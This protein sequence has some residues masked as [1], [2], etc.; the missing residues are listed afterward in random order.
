MTLRDLRSY[1]AYLDERGELATVEQQVEPRFEISA[2]IRR[3]SDA[4]GPA[5]LFNQV[6]NSQMRVVGGLFCSTGKAFHFRPYT[7]ALVQ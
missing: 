2:F 6:A 3:G 1:L 7:P 4:Q 5:F